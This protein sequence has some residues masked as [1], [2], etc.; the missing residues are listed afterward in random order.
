MDGAD[1]SIPRESWALVLAP[2][3][4]NMVIM[5]SF[6]VHA[7][8]DRMCSPVAHNAKVKIMSSPITMAPNNHI[9][10]RPQYTWITQPTNQ[11]LYH[12]S[13]FKSEFNKPFHRCH[14]RTGL[15]CVAHNTYLWSDSL[16][17][18]SHR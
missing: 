9:E 3:S 17:Y 10:G 14:R 16:M 15:R 13:S 2:A 6:P 11:S 1:W 5:Y 18:Q 7:A 4:I 8:K 12:H